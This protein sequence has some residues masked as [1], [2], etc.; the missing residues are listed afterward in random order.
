MS[1][2][3]GLR[4][5]LW[6]EGLGRRLAGGLVALMLMSL[7]AY[8]QRLDPV[9]LDAFLTNPLEAEPRDPLLPTPVVDRRLSPLDL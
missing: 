7:P 8:G 5:Q 2:Y 6:F 9:L 3:F 4:K 1:V